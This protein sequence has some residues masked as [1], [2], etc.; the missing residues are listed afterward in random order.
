MDETAYILTYRDGGG[1]D[2]R[3]TCLPWCTGSDA[4][5]RWK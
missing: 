3:E 5:R 1:G 4:R 2:R